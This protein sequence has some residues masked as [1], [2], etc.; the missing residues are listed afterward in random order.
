MYARLF[1]VFVLGTSIQAC[2]DRGSAGSE[3]KAA[4]AATISRIKDHRSSVGGDN[5]KDT[6]TADARVGVVFSNQCGVDQSTVGLFKSPLP[7]GKE[8]AWF[9]EKKIRKWAAPAV[10][11][12]CSAGEE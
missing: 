2:K 7:A 5:P 12:K 6:L 1:F 8:W 11:Q 3:L 10:G 4:D 9:E